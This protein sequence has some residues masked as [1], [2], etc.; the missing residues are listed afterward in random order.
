MLTELFPDAE[1]STFRTPD[2]LPEISRPHW[3]EG[4]GRIVKIPKIAS[5][6]QLKSLHD[7]VRSDILRVGFSEITIESMHPSTGTV[8]DRIGRDAI[9][10]GKAAT[11]TNW[12]GE[13]H[14]LPTEGTRD[15]LWFKSDQAGRDDR[16]EHVLEYLETICCASYKDAGMS[17]RRPTTGKGRPQS[18]HLTCIVELAGKLDQDPT[19]QFTAEPSVQEIAGHLLQAG[20][21]TAQDL[22][23]ESRTDEEVAQILR[24]LIH[25]QATVNIQDE[26]HMEG[27]SVVKISDT[28]LQTCYSASWPDGNPWSLKMLAWDNRRIAHRRGPEPRGVK[29]SL[30]YRSFFPLVSTT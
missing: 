15:E 12:H 16:E 10:D 4:F 20:H 28:E 2:Q 19:N 24:E 30:L 14:R 26:R 3:P 23:L 7:A 22:G 29:S 5:G 27:K 8:L 18:T 9:S 11:Y 25:A 13:S 6:S 1:V 21:I 17:L